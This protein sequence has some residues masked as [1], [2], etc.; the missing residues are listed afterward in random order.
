MWKSLKLKKPSNK[1]PIFCRCK[2]LA[3]QICWLCWLWTLRYFE[4][5]VTHIGVSWNRGTSKSST[6]RWDFPLQ[7][8]LWDFGGVPFM[9]TPIFCPPKVLKIC[10][11]VR[12]PGM[13]AGMGCHP[14]GLG[15]SPAKIWRFNHGEDQDFSGFFTN[16]ILRCIPLRFYKGVSYFS[17]FFNTW[18]TSTMVYSTMIVAIPFCFCL[19]GLI[20]VCWYTPQIRWVIAMSSANDH[21]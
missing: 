15:F 13:K 1:T 7:I 18:W 12:S 16:G 3:N 14:V 19:G 21:E 6:S 11:V 9:E 17:G 8:Q 2:G 5:L 20:S 10:Q 4:W